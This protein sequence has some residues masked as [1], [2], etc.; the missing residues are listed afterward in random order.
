M[1]G[2]YHASTTG[3][4]TGH[5]PC[6]RNSAALTDFLAFNRHTGSPDAALAANFDTQSLLYGGLRKNDR[7]G[8]KRF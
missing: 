3:A 4:V 6:S 8:K 7:D 5:H 2:V 1:A